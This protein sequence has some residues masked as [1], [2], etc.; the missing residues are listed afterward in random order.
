MKT[1]LLLLVFFATHLVSPF[2]E[3]LNA[4]SCQANPDDPSYPGGIEKMSEFIIRNL[5]DSIKNAG[6]DG[7]VIMSLLVDT[8]GNLKEVIVMHGINPA[9]D[10][11]VVRIFN[12]MPKWNPALQKGKKIEKKIIFPFRFELPEK[13]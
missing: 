13:D 12:L 10:K 9:I 7:R 5:N 8:T 1:T 11:E 6:V 4:Q 3:N 2:M